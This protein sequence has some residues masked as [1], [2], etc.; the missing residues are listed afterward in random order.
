VGHAAPAG[1]GESGNAGRDPGGRA[2]AEKAAGLLRASGWRVVAIRS[3]ADLPG[4]WAQA[5]HT[6]EDFVRDG[7]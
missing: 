5:G 7:A 2:A 4:V 6:G 3:A 1:A